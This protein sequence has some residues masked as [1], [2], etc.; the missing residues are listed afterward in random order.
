[1]IVMICC[2][3]LVLLWPFALDIAKS[4]NVVKYSK[5]DIIHIE[6]AQRPSP[7]A[8]GSKG[9]EAIQTKIPLIVH[10]LTPP[11]DKGKTMN[12]NQSYQRY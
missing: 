3:T 1:M 4:M 12:F 10:Q 6:A 7:V 11:S 9:E 5:L 2:F 8:D